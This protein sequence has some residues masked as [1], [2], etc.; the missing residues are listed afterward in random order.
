MGDNF[1]D[2]YFLG[3]DVGTQG[4]KTVLFDGSQGRVLGEARAGYP[5]VEKADG[6]REQNPA[7]WVDAVNDTI[8]EVLQN[9]GV[10]KRRVHGIGISGQQHGFVPLAADGSVIRPA[11]LW[12]DTST[13]KQ[14]R[15]LIE[16]IGGEQ[17]VLEL[18]G[19]NILAGYTVPK[20]LW[21]KENEPDNYKKLDAILLP[22]DYINFHLTGE[23]V[24]EAGDASGTAYFDVRNRKW[25]SDVL[26][27]VDGDRDLAE[28]LP[29][30]IDS[31]SPAGRVRGEVLEKLGF[32]A[33]HAVIVS[34]GGG[35]NMMAA[36][37]TGNTRKG[38]VTV[39]LGTSGTIYAYS[40][41]PVVDPRAEFAAFCDSTGGWLPLACTMNVTVATELV[42]DL[43]AVSNRELDELVE[44]TPAGSGGLVLLPYF[45]G[46]RTPNVPSGTGVFFG[47]NEFTLKREYL[48]RSAME[49][50]TLGL[51]F[52]LESMRGE[53]IHPTQIRLTGGGSKSDVWCQIA[54]DVFNA[55]TVTM[56]IE[57]AGSLGAAIQAMWCYAHEQGR[58]VNISELTDQYVKLS[59]GEVKEPQ[60]EAVHRYDELFALQNEVSSALR[61]GFEQHRRLMSSE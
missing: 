27:A 19:N 53:G 29:G 24:V 56:E 35:D 6:T 44:K 47:V 21:L 3:C 50:V 8:R 49:G 36:I 23:K 33:G 20:V 58:D 41:F 4:T 34:S 57:E 25:S 12:N 10:E 48:A 43:F 26:Q 17:K 40:D 5:L 32:P 45:V 54:A 9:T 11:K 7:D 42:K 46:E 55:P 61:N 60:A 28:C 2:G 15:T 30:L 39:S 37:G 51:R 1:I 31:I 18:I 38:V 52:G 16:R 13:E 59:S 22:H 14:C